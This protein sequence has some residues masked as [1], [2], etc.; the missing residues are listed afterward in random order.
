MTGTTP[1]ESKKAI[2]RRVLADR[3]RRASDEQDQA[4][5]LLCDQV[6]LLPDVQTAATVAAYYSM[7]DEPGTRPL[8]DALHSRGVTVLLPVLQ[9]D[10]G[11]DWAAH[12]PGRERLNWRGIPEPESA[13]LGPQTLTTASV[14]ICPGMAGDLSGHRLGRGAGCYDQ[15]LAA[16]DHSELRCL[17]LFDDEVLDAVPAQPHDQSV[18]VIV[19]PSRAL[20][21]SAGRY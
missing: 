15:A 5:E 11:L 19:T 4:A 12:E 21:V 2:R 18:D 7:P 13:P 9:P 16:L 10:F 3:G 14:V 1:E 20:W 8:I 17:L 6:M